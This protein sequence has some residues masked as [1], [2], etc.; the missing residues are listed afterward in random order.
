[1]VHILEFEHYLDSKIREWSVVT[2]LNDDHSQIVLDVGQF[3]L[4]TKEVVQFSDQ[5]YAS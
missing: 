5:L 4:V 3:L 1:M 2:I